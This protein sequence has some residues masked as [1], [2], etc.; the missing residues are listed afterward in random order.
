MGTKVTDLTELAATPED[1]DV[2]HIIDV[3]DTTGGSAGTSKKIQVSN[4]PGGSSGTVTSVDVTGG[5]G[6][7]S[8]GGPITT[9]GSITVGI[10]AGGVDTASIADDA[11]TNAKLGLDAVGT[12]EIQDEAVTTDKLVDDAVTGDKLDAAVTDL[13]DTPASLGTAGQ[14]MQVNTGATA[15]E[16]VSP[17]RDLDGLSDVNVG[18]LADR[19]TLIYSSASSEFRNGNLNLAD[20]ADVSSAS[21]TNEQV[22]S[23]NSTSGDWEPRTISG[24][25]GGTNNMMKTFAFFDN[26]VRNVYIPMSSESETSSIQRYNRFVCPVDM[27]VTKIV[28]YTGYTLSGGTGGSV[29]TGSVSGSTFTAIETQSF[30]STTSGGVVTLT[31]TATSFTAGNIYAFKMNNGF[32][33]AYGNIA[34]NILFE[35]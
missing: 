21:P 30:S 17:V 1:D 7:T 2:L 3:S 8:S 11:V 6:I 19:Q 35:V 26:N 14:V 18:S 29:Q 20:A 34:G 12:T 22:L 10:T 33:S 31:F 13:S 32:G 15:L 25:G 16:F 27:D 24:G 28:F 5:T 4:L 9:S 23:Y